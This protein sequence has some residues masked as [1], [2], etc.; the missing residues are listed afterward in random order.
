[1]KRTIPY[2]PAAQ[3]SRAYRAFINQQTA[4]AGKVPSQ[5]VLEQIMASEMGPRAEREYQARLA[6]YRMNKHALA[7]QDRQDEFD[8]RQGARLGSGLT[9][10][11]TTGLTLWGSPKKKATTGEEVQ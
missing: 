9:S 3:S 5:A 2:N 8:S 11:A 6:K 10:L 7:M 1:M 4:T